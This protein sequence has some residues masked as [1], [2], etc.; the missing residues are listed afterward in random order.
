DRY[1]P[2]SVPSSDPLPPPPD[3]SP[4]VVPVTPALGARPPGAPKRR[5]LSMLLRVLRYSLPHKGVLLVSM[6]LMGFQAVAANSRLLMLYPL[7]T[8]VFALDES[9]SEKLANAPPANE[10]AEQKKE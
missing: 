5:S 7:V 8:R 3:P 1:A 4:G 6:A 9:P 10:T 2:G